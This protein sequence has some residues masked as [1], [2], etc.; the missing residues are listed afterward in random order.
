MPVF[1]Y[2]EEYVTYLAEYNGSRDYF[3][4]HE[5][6]E[7]YWKEHPD[8]PYSS[9]WLVL[10]RISVCLYHARRNNWTGAI[11]LM[12]KAAGEVDAKLFDEIGIDGSRMKEQVAMLAQ[13]WSDGESRYADFEL[14]LT[15]ARLLQM[16]KRRCLELGYRWGIGGME[17]G[18]EVIH[19]HRTRDRSD[20]L[21]AREESANRKALSRVLPGSDNRP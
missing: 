15:D 19:R 7:E 4:C 9:C 12:A 13:A 6:M 18:D 1:Q 21:K 5:I 8:S 2:P 3:E 16:A 10:I 14:P 20:V 17:A 11:K